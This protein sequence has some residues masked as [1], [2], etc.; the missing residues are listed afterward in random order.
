MAAAG[1]QARARTQEAGARDRPETGNRTQ[2]GEDSR[3]EMETRAGAGMGEGEREEGGGGGTRPGTG[4]G[5]GAGTGTG[6]GEGAGK[7]AGD[8]TGAGAGAGAGEGAG[9]RTRT[10]AGAGTGTGTGTGAGGTEV[11][12]VGARE[13]ARV[14]GAVSSETRRPGRGRTRRFVDLLGLT[15]APPGPGLQR[16]IKLEHDRPRIER[17]TWKQGARARQTVS[18]RQRDLQWQQ[19]KKRALFSNVV[20]VV[21]IWTRGLCREDS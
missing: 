4:A 11:R 5:A 12:L 8:G 1:A 7:W 20:K 6:T 13:E 16:R 15:E 2:A 17:R 14:A 18:P 10:G 9:T 19:Q 21:E 3:W